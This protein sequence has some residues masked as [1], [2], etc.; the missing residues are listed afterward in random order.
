MAASRDTSKQNV[1]ICL[2]RQTLRKA[3]VLSV[4]RG[5][6]VSD[7]LAEQIEILVGEDEAYGRAQRQATTL[8]DQGFRMG[9]VIRC[10]R[11]ELHNR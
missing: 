3:E 6:S 2:N 10:T 11:D 4:R 7:F 9:D 1:T 8:L 5:T